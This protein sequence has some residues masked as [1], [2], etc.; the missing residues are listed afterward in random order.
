MPSITVRCRCESPTARA[1]GCTSR[2]SGNPDRLVERARYIFLRDQRLDLVRSALD[3]RRRPRPGTRCAGLRRRREPHRDSSATAASVRASS[4]QG[5]RAIGILNR[6]SA[7]RWRN[8]TIFAISLHP[9]PIR[10]HPT[11]ARLGRR[12]HGA[13]DRL[14]PLVYEQLRRLAANHMRK[15]RPGQG[16]R[17]RRSFTRPTCAW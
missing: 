15:E 13:L 6:V 4:E 1:A 12:R 3:R 8:T 14:T 7:K 16:C 11:A 5:H 10:N 2:S 9:M 17:R